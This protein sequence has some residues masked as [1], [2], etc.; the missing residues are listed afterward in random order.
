MA[1]RKHRATRLA[2]SSGRRTI[3]RRLNIGYLIVSLVLSLHPT[4]G[5]EPTAWPACP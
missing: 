4:V 3:I 2:G 5:A 1:D